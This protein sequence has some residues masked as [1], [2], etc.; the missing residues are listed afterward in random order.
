MLRTVGKFYIKN[1]KFYTRNDRIV[2]VDRHFRDSLR[3]H[4]GKATESSIARTSTPRHRLRL[5]HYTE[6]TQSAH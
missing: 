4:D 2:P 6:K 5:S 3:C 1:I